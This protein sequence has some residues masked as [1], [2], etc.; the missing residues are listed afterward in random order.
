ML[1]SKEFQRK[2][3]KGKRKMFNSIAEIKE[4][5]DNG[6][7]TVY[8]KNTNYEVRKFY[9]PKRKVY[10]YYICCFSTKSYFGLTYETKKGEKLNGKLEDFFVI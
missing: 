8:W 4:Y 3:K 1:K 10:E 6:C 2:Q 9:F 5:V 7:K